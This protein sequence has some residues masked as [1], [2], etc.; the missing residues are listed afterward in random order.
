MKM[1]CKIFGCKWKKSYWFVGRSCT[2]CHAYDQS[3]VDQMEA[4]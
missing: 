3:N 4:K 1:L 2:R